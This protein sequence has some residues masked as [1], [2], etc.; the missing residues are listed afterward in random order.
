MEATAVEPSV[1]APLF[2]TVSALTELGVTAAVFYV[3]AQAYY[4][5]RFHGGLLTFALT[6]EVLFNVA[7]M[8]RQLIT[9]SPE[10]DRPGWLTALYAGHG[11]LSLVM[12]LALI[13]FALAAFRQHKYGINMFQEQKGM[14]LAFVVLWSISIASGEAIYLVEYVF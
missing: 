2:S 10:A 11:L 8:V 9:E 12:L 5:D 1:A 4:K 6:Y 7:Y 14:T 3:I 13:V